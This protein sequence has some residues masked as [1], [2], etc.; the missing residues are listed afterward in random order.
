VPGLYG[1]EIKGDAGIKLEKREESEENNG[2]SQKGTARGVP[3]KLKRVVRYECIKG[4]LRRKPHA[5]IKKK[6]KLSQRGRGQDLVSGTNDK[7][8]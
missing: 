5:S 4:G 7:E 2:N 6:R 1:G 8:T 3:E